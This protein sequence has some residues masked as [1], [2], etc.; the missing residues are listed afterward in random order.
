MTMI[1]RTKEQLGR[2][3]EAIRK[4][5]DDLYF[6]MLVLYFLSMLLE[7][8]GYTANIGGS[9]GFVRNTFTAFF[10]VFFGVFFVSV[11]FRSSAFFRRIRKV[12]VLL[13]V[14]V[15]I[16]LFLWLEDAQFNGAMI[17]ILAVG[18]Y[19][20]DY[21]NILKNFFWCMAAT[22]IA[23]GIGIPV[24]LTKEI[25]KV[26]AYG[27]GLSFGFSHANVWGTF[28]VMTFLLIWYLFEDNRTILT[29]RVFYALSW[30]L[31]VFMVIVPKC[32]TGALLLF[33]FPLMSVL[34]RGVIG[35]PGIRVFRRRNRA[36][37]IIIC[38][39]ILAPFLCYLI[40]LILG[41]QR[42]WLVVHTFGNYTENFSK[43]FIQ[44]GLAFKEHGFPL[45]GERIRFHSGP[46]E[47]L[48][49]Y[50]I[51]LYV[52]DNSYAAFT[53]LRG[54]VWMVPAL[55]WLSYAN[56]KMIRR[57]DHYLLTISVLF[58]LLAMM[59]R[60]PFEIYNF[61]FLYPLASASGCRG[62]AKI[63]RISGSYGIYI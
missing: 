52:L 10:L 60:Y 2:L 33:L 7:C 61:V 23:A 51:G 59:E 11:I 19:G 20:R 18:A 43:R 31:G 42:E 6:A 41:S 25:P 16:I 29:R 24:G 26:G 36:R 28:A 37:G 62:S 21:R 8:V 4:T 13:P 27:T 50:K 40:T 56:W 15:V 47:H 49:N 39:L 9:N 45:I 3:A 38:V 44:S 63:Q 1:S 35:D 30:I 46:A 58:C 48:G 54:L 55:L 22:I 34:C 5:P 12:W 53:I 32:R 14:S 57:K 17:A